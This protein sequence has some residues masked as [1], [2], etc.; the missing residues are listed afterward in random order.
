MKFNK[1]IVAMILALAMVM[2]L[3]SVEM[4]EDAIETAEMEAESDADDELVITEE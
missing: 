1:A 4:A 3:A 2:G